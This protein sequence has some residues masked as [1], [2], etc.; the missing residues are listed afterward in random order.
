LALALAVVVAWPAWATVRAAWRGPEAVSGAGLLE[1]GVDASSV[2]RPLALAL[3]TIELVLATEALALGFGLPLALL[4]GRTDLWGRRVLFGLMALGMFVP[5]PLHAAAWL[6]AFG[7]V[8]RA[9]VFGTRPVLLGLPGAAFVHA[10]AALPWVVLLASLGLRTV[11]P[12]LEESALLEKPAWRVLASVT[13]RRGLGAIA[14]AALAVA[15]L[16]AGDMTVTDLLQVR[17]YAEEA[18]TQFQLGNGP[19]AAA[20]VALPPLLVLGTLVLLG[21]HGLLKA[22]PARLASAQAHAKVW[23][24]GRWRIPLGA[25]VVFLAGNLVALPV[26]GL[27]WR[28]GRVGGSAAL[29][30]PPHWSAGGLLGTLQYAAADVAEPLLTSLLW[31]A[32]GATVTLFLAWPLAWVSR[33]KS[34][35]QWVAAATVGLCLAAPGPVAGM[36]LV[37]AYNAAPPGPGASAF[38][39]LAFHVRTFIY[40]TPGILVLAY[41]LRTLPYALL[42]LWPALRALPPAYLEAAALD[43]HGPWGQVRRVAIPLT[44]PAAGAAWG[45]SFVLALG[46]LP[47]ANLVYPPGTTPLSVVVWGLLHTGVESHLAGVGVILL[48]TIAAAG[49]LV[50]CAL[51]TLGERKSQTVMHQP[52]MA[53]RL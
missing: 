50:A 9:Q 6:G 8:G 15:V 53:T 26:Y 20:T 18:Y 2:A 16:T 7:N 27:L 14:A 22:D 17:T 36:A 44:L 29:G 31:A 21:A 47:T 32:L 51:A 39:T 34:A 37:L 28:A 45:V 13:V 1:V 19:G 49:L 25:L 43:G 4:L 30:Q 48:A 52:M 24:L 10:M 35:W 46:E 38:T 11:E 40:D 23:R 42:V 33:R 12:E 5:M 3:N 41:V